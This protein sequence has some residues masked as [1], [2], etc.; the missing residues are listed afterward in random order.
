MAQTLRP[1]TPGR[2]PRSQGRD[3]VPFA[4]VKGPET[5]GVP[6]VWYVPMWKIRRAPVREIVRRALNDEDLVVE[7]LWDDARRVRL[8][9]VD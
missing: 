6:T 9:V 8:A 4:V 5:D 2:V 3:D 1:Q 7:E